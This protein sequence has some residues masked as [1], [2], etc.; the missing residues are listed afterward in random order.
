MAPSQ[1]PK[2]N[3]LPRGPVM[4]ICIMYFTNALAPTILFPF[5]PL[6]VASF[7]VTDDP[8]KLGYYAGYLGSSY[9]VGSLLTSSFWGILSDQW[10][11][12]PVLLIGLATNM[13]C[14]GAFGLCTSFHWAMLVRFLHGLFS[15]VAATGRSTV[16][17]LC[18]STNQAQ[19]FALLGTNFGLGLL[20]GPALGG[21]LCEPAVKYPWLFPPRS[22]F[23][24]FPF[25][26]PCLLLALLSLLGLL[27]TAALLPETKGWARPVV[28]IDDDLQSDTNSG[29]FNGGSNSG[30]DATAALLRETKGWAHPV[31]DRD[32]DLHGHK[33]C[34]IEECGSNEG[35]A[36]RNVEAESGGRRETTVIRVTVA[37]VDSGSCGSSSSSSRSSGSDSGS[38]RSSLSQPLLQSIAEERDEGE[39]EEEWERGEGGR[40]GKRCEC[41]GGDEVAQGQG[42]QQGSERRAGSGDVRGGAHAAG[43]QGGGARGRGVEGSGVASMGEGTVGQACE[44]EGK[45]GAGRGGG[46]GGGGVGEG[47]GE[48]DKDRAD[49][50]DG[51]RARGDLNHLKDHLKDHLNGQ[52]L[53]E[54]LLSAGGEEDERHA[55]RRYSDGGVGAFCGGSS[56]FC[57]CLPQ[58]SCCCLPSCLPHPSL[59][60]VGLFSPLCGQ[61]LAQALFDSATVKAFLFLALLSFATTA[62]NEVFPL[63][64]LTDWRFG[65]LSFGTNQVAMAQ[66]CA[67][68]CSV[69][70]QLYV[71]APLVNRVGARG[72]VQVSLSVGFVIVTWL[73]FIRAF[74]HGSQAT[75]IAACLSLAMRSFAQC[76]F[77][78]GFIF[79]NNSITD[80]SMLGA[81]T[82]ITQSINLFF[83][84]MAPAA[85][86]SVFA[87]S[88]SGKGFF[89]FDYHFFFFAQAALQLVLIL[90]S[91]SMPDHIDK[92]K[93]VRRQT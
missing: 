77:T 23:A 92:P 78:S 16:A 76:V 48:Y 6:M 57:S 74:G 72:A 58:L 9:F 47:W 30:S 67:G 28:N 38:R 88:I 42:G 63:W 60:P 40:E 17:E 22:L 13:V 20:I 53:R 12:K 59:S 10:G 34:D 89:P 64:S 7:A 18:D 71:Y 11:R 3:P 15:T 86:A 2:P 54:P 70:F 8:T 90:I 43:G 84:A 75:V 5:L 82:G 33:H 19:G 56:W 68:I 41:R 32:S 49:Y 79:I 62:F 61:Q 81:V 69:I 14:G 26:L 24:R 27:A 36:M 29:G 37:S 31:V 39:E 1:P 87:W 45:G 46:C 4:A 25:L 21:F 91:R 55:G 83:R 51:S 85:G 73:P 66:T 93:F 50:R 44:G 35:G 52:H 80:P 65:G